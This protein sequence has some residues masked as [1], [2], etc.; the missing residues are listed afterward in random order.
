MNEINF[1]LNDDP[2]GWLSNFERAPQ[3][4]DGLVYY[5]NEHFYQHRKA[6]NPKLAQWIA[7][8]PTPYAAMMAGRSL[9]ENE[10]LENWED[11][12]VNVMLEGLVAKFSQNDL[13][14]RLLLETGDAVLH[15]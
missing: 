15:E 13:L 3:I 2:Y 5:T 12:K 10:K 11:L 4:V 1:Y 8:A 7:S 14:R 6:K 9:R